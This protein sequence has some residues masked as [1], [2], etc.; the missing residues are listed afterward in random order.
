MSGLIG[1]KLGMTQIFTEDG[2]AVGVTVLEVGPCP[3]VQVRTPERDGYS[4]VQLGFGRRRDRRTR[5]P[6]AGHAARAGLDYV[7]EVLA[8]F[9]AQEG[10]AYEPGEQLTVDMFE[11]GQ[12]VKISGRIK[13]RGFQGVVKRHGF[14]GGRKS[15][16]G[17]SIL[18]APG[19]IGPG[20]DPSRVIK[21]RKMAGQMGNT[22]RTASNRRIER[23]DAEKNL[24]MVRGS[25]PGSRNN[26]VLIRPAGKAN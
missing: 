17:S 5:K 14:G 13:G 26:I 1:R 3:V 9:E 21:G 25:V 12:R 24:L 4:A 7:P 15:H 11:V 20:T 8:E 19:S 22:V 2:K 16:G 10:R 23:I 18:R 6:A